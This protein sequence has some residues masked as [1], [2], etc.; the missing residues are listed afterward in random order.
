MLRELSNVNSVILAN[1]VFNDKWALNA[2][3]KYCRMLPGSTLQY[4]LPALCE[5]QS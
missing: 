3:Q 2:G 1:C 4:F 5:N